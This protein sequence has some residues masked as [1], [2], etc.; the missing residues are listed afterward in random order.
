[1]RNDVTLLID[2]QNALYKYLSINYGLEHNN[3]RTGGIYGFV[4]HF[5]HLINVHKPT[6]VI[7]CNDYPPYKR[8][9]TCA[10]YK[11]DRQKL[12][13]D[14]F[15]YIQNSKKFCYKFLEYLG[16]PLW[17]EKGF[18][19][20]DLFG[21]Y[22]KKF[23]S[24]S[25]ILSSNDNDLNQLLNAKISIYKQNKQYTIDNFRQ[26]F[27]I[28]PDDWIKVLAMSGTHNNLKNLYKGL[29]I[30][31]AIKIL[32]D[33]VKMDNMLFSYKE[34]YENNLKLIKL[35]YDDTITIPDFGKIAIIDSEREAINYLMREFGIRI[36]S[37]M[38]ESFAILRSTIN[39]I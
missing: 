21:A 16:I 9:V 23:D 4:T 34:Q 7:V 24:E 26:E 22:C 39:L 29:G 36:T 31:T 19:C 13:D 8:S 38:N 28:E 37:Q 3:I 18:E 20:D 14:L 30:K 2:F 33:K 11:G 10:E 35:P 17:F 27:N 1:L 6:K 25:I 5:S 32:K 12:E 15:D